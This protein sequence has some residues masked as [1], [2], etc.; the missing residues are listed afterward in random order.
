MAKTKTFAE[1]ML[2][3]MKP[4]VDFDIYK[5]ITAKPGPKGAMRYNARVVKIKK[6]A[7]EK[8]ALGL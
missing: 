2:K 7:D 5:V 4:A 8:A 6:D 1:K 3:S